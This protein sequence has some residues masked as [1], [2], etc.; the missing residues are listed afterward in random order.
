MKI[1]GIDIGSVSISIS[2]ID[3]KKTILQYSYTPHEGTIKK[4][5]TQ[6]LQKYNLSEISA[7]AITNDTP[8][9]FNNFV[10]F[11]TRVS[12]INAAKY[13]F[14]KIGSLMI[15]GGEKFGLALF[16]EQG[17]YTNYKANSS[18]AA[19]TGSFLDQQSK[20]MNIKSIQD[21]S[22]IALKNTGDFPK[23]ASRC[24]VFAKTDL[25]HAQQEGYSKDEIADGLSFGLAKN[26][27]DSLFAGTNFNQPLIFV[28]GVSQNQAVKKHISSILNTEIITHKFG[29]IFGAV[30]AAF[31]L[32]EKINSG[33]KINFDQINSVSDLIF[34]EKINKDFFYDKLEIKY[35]DYPD[36]SSLEKYDF[37]S[38]IFPQL[39]PIE[40][41]IYESLNNSNF[42]VHLGV[43][44]GSTSTKAALIDSKK[45]VLVGLYT[46]TSGQ[47]VSAVQTILEAI[48]DIENTK[49]VK[50]NIKSF[51][52]TGS[53]RKFIGKIFGSDLILNEIS[54]HAKAAY[55]LDPEV[56]TIIE[57]GGQDSKFTT[58]RNGLVTFSIMN[59][60]CAAGTGSFI[61]EQAK[62]LNVSLSDFANLAMDIPAPFAS[63]RCT[64]FMERDLNQYL[65]KGYSKNEILATVT[66][67]IRENYLTK[68]A[69]ESNIGKKIFFQGATAKN[70]ALVASFEQKLKR[71]IIVSKFCHLTGAIGVALE[72]IDDS[73]IKT[74][75]RGFDMFNKNIPVRTE[76]CELCT[77]HCKLKIAEINGEIE[78]YGFL[79]GRD[80][81]VQKFVNNNKSGFNIINEYNN[82]FKYTAEKKINSEKKIG[83]PAALY[84]MEEMPKWR[85]FFELLNIKT[86]SSQK[87]Q[88]PIKEGKNIANAEFCAPMA[89]VH[90]HINFLTDKSDYVFLPTY[91]E[92]KTKEKKLRREYC[93]YTQYMPAV[94]SSN[95]KFKTTKFISPLL[96]SLQSDYVLKLNLYNSLKKAGFDI[97]VFDVNNA[98]DKAEK[99]F[100]NKQNKWK[101]LFK[102]NFKDDKNIKVVLLGRPYTV[103]SSKMN[104]GIPDI[105][106]KNNVKTYF[107][108]MLDLDIENTEEL[109]HLLKAMKWNYA[110]EILAI[111]EKIA[112]TD[113]LYPVFVTSF[114]C[115]PD[116]FALEYFKSIME[117]H[118]KPYLI[119][120]LDEHD[121]SVGYETRI[122]AAI[123]SFQNHYNFEHKRQKNGEF[124]CNQA[125]V[126]T[127]SKQLKGKT[128]LFPDWDK[129]ITPLIIASMKNSG[130]KAIPLSDTT[131]SIQQSS[132]LNTGQCIPLSI[133]IQNVID[134]VTDKKLDP[135]N[136]VVWMVKN[137]LACNFSMYPFFLKKI[138]TDKS[139]TY[140]GLEKVQVYLGELSFLD[141]SFNTGINAYFSY[142][143]GGYLKKIACKIRP[144]EINKGQTN[145]TIQKS[146]DLLEYV[147]ENGESKEKA[148]TKII[149]DFKSIPIKKEKK[150]KVAV[151]GDL[152]S[153][154]NEELN[155]N[156]IEFI[157][158]NGGEVL[159]TPYS[160]YLKLIATPYMQRHF[161]QGNYLEAATIK[162]IELLIPIVENKYY[163]Y[164]NEI[165]QEDPV[166]LSDSFKEKLNMFNIKPLNFGESFDN[167]LKV[168]H[169]SETHKD[170]SLF[171]QANPAYCAASIVTESMAHKIQEITGIPVVTIEYDA[172][173]TSKNSDLIPYLQFSVQKIKENTDNK[174]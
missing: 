12:F 83:I 127:S 126:L 104:S 65:R 35:S 123:R 10:E 165:L 28:G 11:D 119:L 16:D 131:K 108:D 81:N 15:V 93:Y 88:Q 138:L 130:F 136:T 101:L 5:L 166:K 143:S 73:S 52:T 148:I 32:L 160:E 158:Q 102:E 85:K 6:E 103:L 114:K 70:K 153:R 56:D 120:Q 122:E 44:I 14:D 84:L 155:Q 124:E 57:I 172:T 87:A 50:F 29:K 98:Y 78:A 140:P 8:K 113:S 91:L 23:I 38:V 9:I 42:D 147:I 142:M 92:N 18:C 157:E 152:Y 174:I 45:R 36:F 106:G 134:I 54:A 37:K 76:I 121:S 68:V 1:L 150:P 31:M 168:I 43:D 26:L 19:G 30:G 141:F 145:K 79:C 64:V 115:S 72:M 7:V 111:S 47:P 128:I 162:F 99:Y 59:N 41:D 86:I 71:P 149:A 139:Y 156:L 3:S 105:F 164:F 62:K 40:T 53:G 146:L 22:E 61:E 109:N 135:E 107:Q 90:A 39:V 67:S 163:K 69:I 89:A 112:K 110:A 82:I 60:V 21:F 94:V 48:I 66:H 77:N 4:T 46:R 58:L 75:F 27:V 137:N 2:L 125:N 133:I 25:I 13:F 129:T 33:E 17:N 49:N 24:A 161:K 51:G 100:K 117:K 151:F 171:V 34:A 159:T 169:L 116:S 118:Q 154:D 170:L 96:N 167:A 80:Y 173:L 63:D 55:E 95:S 74:K 20:R 97:S 144:Y 132:V